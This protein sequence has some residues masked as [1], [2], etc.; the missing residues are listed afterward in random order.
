MMKPL[1]KK[2]AAFD[3]LAISPTYK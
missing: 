1:K 3:T 2:A